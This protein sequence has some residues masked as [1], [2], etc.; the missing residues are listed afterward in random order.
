MKLQIDTEAKT[1]AIEDTIELDKLIKAL[2]V[3]FPNDEWKKYKLEPKVIS[4]WWN[5]IVIDRYP[6]YP[7]NPWPWSPIIYKVDTDIM[8]QTTCAAP[9]D[10]TTMPP[11][12][13]F[14]VS[15]S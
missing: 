1:I 9:P 6:Q 3:M 12:H 10:N 7:A 15:L 5:P 14:N 2:R 8:C 13:I 4:N 11:N